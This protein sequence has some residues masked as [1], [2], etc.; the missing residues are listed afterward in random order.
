MAIE[1]S[2]QTVLSCVESNDENNISDAIFELG[3]L[4]DDKGLIPDDVSERLLMI[5]VNEKMWESPLAAHIL[6][7]FEFGSPH[8]SRCAKS[9]C[10]DFLRAYGDR[11]RHF[12]SRQVVTEL[13]FGPYLRENDQ[14]GS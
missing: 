7:F 3:K 9:L 12:H 10:A 8:L 6:N 11:F 4:A 14:P 2:L 5:L 1:V 13:R